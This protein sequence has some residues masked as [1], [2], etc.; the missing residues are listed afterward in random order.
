VACGALGAAPTTLS[1]AY[2]R[3]GEAV[4]DVLLAK[5]HEVRYQQPVGGHDTV[6]WRGTFA[7][8]LLALLGK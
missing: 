8:G 6:S 5:G 7:D 3:H 4:G 2:Q 1:A